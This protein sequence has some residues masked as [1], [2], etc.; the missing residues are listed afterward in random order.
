VGQFDAT[1]VQL[2]PTC[3]YMSNFSGLEGIILFSAANN[4]DLYAFIFEVPFSQHRMLGWQA[5]P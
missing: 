3:R 1:C 5:F 4:V 2:R